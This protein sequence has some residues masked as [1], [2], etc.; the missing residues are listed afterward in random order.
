MSKMQTKLD[1]PETRQQE[2]KAAGKNKQKENNKGGCQSS[3][4][5]TLNK[6]AQR[7]QRHK[8]QLQQRKRNYTKEPRSFSQHETSTC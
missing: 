1:R 3:Q 6:Y 2:L 4:T 8:K 7:I 5:N